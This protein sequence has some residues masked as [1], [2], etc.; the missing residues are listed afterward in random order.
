MDLGTSFQWPHAPTFRFPAQRGT[1]F[2]TARGAS[3]R[4][5]IFAARAQRYVLIAHRGRHSLLPKFGWRFRGHGR[6]LFPI[7]IILSAVSR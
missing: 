2:L 1:Y 7:L 4:G 5:T 6:L 3:A